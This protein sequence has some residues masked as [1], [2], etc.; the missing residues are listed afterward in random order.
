M[1]RSYD[2]LAHLSREKFT[3]AIRLWISRAFLAGGIAVCWWI[4]SLPACSHCSKTPL[5]LTLRDG[6]LIHAELYAPASAGPHRAAV[7]VCHGYMG[8]AGFLEVPWTEDLTHLGLVA[9]FVDR[10]GHGMSGGAWWPPPATDPPPRLADLD[11]DIHAAVAYL[12]AQ[13]PLIDPARIA[14][15]GH[16][17]GGTAAI[18][19]ASADWNI[20]ATVALSASVAPWE[21]VNH[22]A[23]SNLLLIYG[24]DDRFVL[25][26]TDLFLIDAATR[27]YLH[28]EGQ[29]GAFD[30]GSARRLL[31]VPGHGRLDVLNSDAARRTALEW[32][33]RALA[34]DGEVRLAPLRWRWV[35]AGL[36]LLWVLVAGWNGAPPPVAV[37]RRAQA[38]R[39]AACGRGALDGGAG[40]GELDRPTVRRRARPGGRHRD[41]RAGGNR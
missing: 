14:L 32:L 5:W 31:R 21:Y 35:V 13:A 20:A 33:A 27:G 37:R 15:L 38:R 17:D 30:D 11:P 24:A 18:I 6:T 34:V 9:L 3:R 40:A 23:P 19:A 10:R 39:Q 16:S 1:P 12:R 28:G 7:V 22:V 4:G 41:R 36:A 25:A 26:D 29:V 8:N 2:D